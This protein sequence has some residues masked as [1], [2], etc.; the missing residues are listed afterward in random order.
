MPCA[1]SCVSTLVTYASIT[2]FSQ[3]EGD[4]TPWR[5][6]R[7]K[8]R[9]P[10]RYT[11]IGGMPRAARRGRRPAQRSRRRSRSAGSGGRSR[12][13]DRRCRRWSRARS[14]GARKRRSPL[15]P[16]A[17]TTSSNG[18]IRLM[19]SGSPRSRRA[20]VAEHLAAS[21]RWKSVSA[22]SRRRP[23]SHGMPKG[24]L[25]QCGRPLRRRAR[26]PCRCGGG[27]VGGETA[28]PNWHWPEAPIAGARLAA[29]LPEVERDEL[30]AAAVGEQ[31]P[32]SPP[33]PTRGRRRARGAA[34]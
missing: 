32:S 33:R 22:S 5:P 30:V 16:R 20:S 2:V 27:A 8:R 34:R 1:G 14:S 23:V 29:W 17:C 26:A 10:M 11:E 25:R 3:R 21:A 12:G 6:S 24:V 28:S 19:S 15:R 31:P 18:R 13:C 9:S 4:D 7:T